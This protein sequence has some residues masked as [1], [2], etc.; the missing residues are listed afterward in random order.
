MAG[1]RFL[2][3]DQLVR[4]FQAGQ[5]DAAFALALTLQYGLYTI[6]LTASRNLST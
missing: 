6:N 2:H 5:F 3:I 1:Y 4:D